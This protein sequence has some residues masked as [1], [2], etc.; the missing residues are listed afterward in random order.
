MLILETLI[1]WIVNF[2]DVNYLDLHFYGNAY[3]GGGGQCPQVCVRTICNLAKYFSPNQ[4]KSPP[5]LFVLAMKHQQHGHYH[6][7]SR[8]FH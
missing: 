2:G 6:P 1:T 7:Q 8:L 4:K 5:T 3:K